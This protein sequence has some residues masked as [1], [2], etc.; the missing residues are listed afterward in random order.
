MS[1][2]LFSPYLRKNKFSVKGNSIP[3]ENFMWMLPLIRQLRPDLCKILPLNHNDFG[4]K[5]IAWL[6]NKGIYEYKALIEHPEFLKLSACQVSSLGLTPLQIL[7]YLQHQNVQTIYPLPNKTM[8]IINWFYHYGV[9]EYNLWSLLSSDEW[10]KIPQKIHKLAKIQQYSDIKN[11]QIPF[12]I[13]LIGHPYADVGIGEDIRMVAKSIKLANIP[14]AIINFPLGKD[15]PQNNFSMADYVTEI[16]TYKINIFC[17]TALETARFY[18]GREKSQFKERYNIGYWTW[19]L[20][21]WPEELMN[22]FDL[23]DEIW[24]PSRYAYDAIAPVSP[25]PVIFMPLAV[26]VGEI[27][28]KAR[29]DFGLPETAYLYFVYFDL[30]TFIYKK[31]LQACINAFLEAFPFYIDTPKTQQKVGLVIKTH[32]Y[33]KSNPRWKEL[34]KRINKDNRFYII[35][36][37]LSKPDLFALYKCC[38]CFLSLHNAKFFEKEIS[39]ALLLGLQVITPGNFGNLDFFIDHPNVNLINYTLVPLKKE[40]YAFSKGEM[41]AEPDITHA[42]FFIRKCLHINN[43]KKLLPSYPFELKNITKHYKQRINTI[44]NIC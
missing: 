5:F 2:S 4:I 11:S 26:E 9:Q 38:N 28:D 12:G 27:S 8:D 15:I 33:I 40:E 7:T 41:L 32:Q 39:Q 19:E 36:R 14:F 16:V 35:E 6:L 18:N 43:T 29:P 13:N 17:M 21:Q 22:L 24:V 23:V 10:F 42:A 44:N 1:K 30:D 34:K 37:T 31:N 3:I 25:V 20:S